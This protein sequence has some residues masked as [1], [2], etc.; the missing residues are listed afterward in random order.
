MTR[1][2]VTRF[3]ETRTVRPEKNR[4]APWVGRFLFYAGKL[5]LKLF[6]RAG[7]IELPTTAW[8]AVVLP[9]N[10]ARNTE[11]YSTEVVFCAQKA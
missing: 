2:W 9:L 3:A 4:Q 7:R 6:V 11:E 1:I 5:E 8:K 10:H